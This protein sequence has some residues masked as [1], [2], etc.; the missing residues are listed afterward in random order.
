VTAWRA[1]R[2]STIIARME[3][4]WL[5]CTATNSF[6]SLSISAYGIKGH[7]A[8]VSGRDP[9]LHGDH[10]HHRSSQRYPRR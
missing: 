7:R 3:V 10:R 5:A 1:S 9:Q 2:W 4:G 8:A 6:V